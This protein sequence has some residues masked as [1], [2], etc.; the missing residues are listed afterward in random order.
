[1]EGVYLFSIKH[2]DL[3]NMIREAVAETIKK[4]QKPRQILSKAEACRRLDCSFRTFQKMLLVT[5]RDFIYD[6]EVEAIKNEYKLK[7][8]TA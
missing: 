1:M 6:D 2:D 8:K 3:M 4:N 7:R 5:N